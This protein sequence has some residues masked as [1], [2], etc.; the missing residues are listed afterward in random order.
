M[1]EQYL[2]KSPNESFPITGE[3]ALERAIV[4]AETLAKRDGEATVWQSGQLLMSFRV[5]ISP[6]PKTQD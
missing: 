3:E 4:V 5:E 2:V 6:E 1:S